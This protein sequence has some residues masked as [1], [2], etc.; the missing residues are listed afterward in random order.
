MRRFNAVQ[1]KYDETKERAEFEKNKASLDMRYKNLPEVFQR[2]IGEFRA[3]DP[4]FRWSEEY[5]EMFCC[6][7]A[8]AISTRISK[9]IIEE[10]IDEGLA[11]VERTKEVIIERAFSALD[12]FSS[13]DWEKKK[14]IVPNLSSGHSGN[15]SER[16]VELAYLY[17]QASILKILK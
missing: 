8:V 3:N 16:S 15:S 5:Y 7:Q 4:D 17:I 14:E 1:V 11:L 2:R 10:A 12:E 6:E 9:R 13:M